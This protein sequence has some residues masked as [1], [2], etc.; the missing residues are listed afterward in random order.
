VQFAR[1]AVLE[2]YDVRPE[3]IEQSFVFDQLP[4]GQGDLV[5]QL[6]LHTELRLVA[7]DAAGLRFES[8]DVGGVSIG[9]VTGIDGK[10]L[11]ASGT[12]TCDGRTLQLRLPAAFVDGATLPLV[13]DPQIG[14]VVAVTNSTVDYQEPELTAPFAAGGTY[15]CVFE[16]E[17]S[18]S[19]HD[20]RG[21]RLNANGTTAGG[22]FA[23][24]TGTGNDRNPCAAGITLRNSWVVVHERAGDLFVRSVSGSGA[25][26]SE[27]SAVSGADNQIEPAL[28]SEVTLAD[29][30]AL[31]VFRNTTQNSIQTCEVTLF[32]N[33]ILAV[34]APFTIATSLANAPLGG[35]RI[36]HDGGDVGRFLIV[37]PR[38]PLLADSKTQLV[39]I[40]RDQ[41][42]L[43]SGVLP[44][45]S[46][47]EDSPDVDGDGYTWIV[48][49]EREPN[50]GSGDNGIYAA[51]VYYDAAV[52]ILRTSFPVAVTALVN[53]DEIDPVVACFRSSSCL[54]GW[55][56]RAAPGSSDTE[57]FLKTIDPWTCTQCE[58]TVLLAN[59]TNIETNLA[60]A[61]DPFTEDQGLVLWET[62]TLSGGNGDLNGIAWQAEDG[63]VRTPTGGQGCGPAMFATGGCA[64]VGN[65]NFH[66]RVH[67]VATATG[68][69]SISTLML[70][71]G[72]S[73]ILCGPCRLYADPFGGF[74]LGPDAGANSTI[75]AHLAIPNDS[76]LRGMTFYVQW[77]V[78][79]AAG[80]CTWLQADFTN[81]IA[82]TIE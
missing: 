75:N 42:V 73:Q 11:R 15:L 57:V 36:A 52:G 59:T 51:P 45:N 37:F 66:V 68:G 55:R 34:T 14:T 49:F 81:A 58:P 2:R 6:A 63:V 26:S 40:D 5:V 69:T 41:T 70:S 54:I 1:G 50:E 53:V 35:P 13:L 82:I 27:H 4:P 29:D 80:A 17:I 16:R 77:L 79:N 43:A 22:L 12:I 19:D 72:T 3:G 25:V 46:D 64:R 7:T 30:D 8:A 48:A 10:G 60:A 24:T 65:S 61:A 67:D 78:H 74:A 47:D 71:L 28:G 21:I 44:A 31:L 39:L 20:I 23:I 62:S 18:A 33:G 9:A 56:R 76:T 38:T 32:S